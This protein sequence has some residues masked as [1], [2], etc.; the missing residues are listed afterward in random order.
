[1]E[2]FTVMGML[3]VWRAAHM[4]QNENGPWAI[5]A[6]FEAWIAKNGKDT[7]GSFTEGFFCFYCLSMWLAFIV[8]LL[9][10]SKTVGNFFIQWFAISAGAIF[11]NHI[12]E[13]IKQ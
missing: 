1:M 11:I 4:L 3:A 7:P 9:L 10:D 12:Y 2:F 5:F 13:K 8:A 6:R